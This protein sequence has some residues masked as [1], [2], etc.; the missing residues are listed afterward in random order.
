MKAQLN[1]FVQWFDNSRVQNKYKYSFD[2]SID[3]LRCIPFMGLHLGCFAVFFVG[4]SMTSIVV[5]LILYTVRMFAITGFY[6][7]P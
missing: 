3:W 1:S 2:E 4:W 7:L 5:A 6:H